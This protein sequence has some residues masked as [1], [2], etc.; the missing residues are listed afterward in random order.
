MWVSPPMGATVWVPL[1]VVAVVAAKPVPCP[2]A[3]RR[4]LG[5]AL[6]GLTPPTRAPLPCPHGVAPRGASQ[7][8]QQPPSRL[9]RARASRGGFWLSASAEQGRGRA[10]DLVRGAPSPLPSPVSFP[11]KWCVQPRASVGSGRAG[12]TGEGEKGTWGM[13]SA[14]GC[15]GN[16]GL[17][18]PFRLAPGV[19]LA[20]TSAGAAGEETACPWL[21]LSPNPLKPPL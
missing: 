15:E 20:Q 17:S 13:W 14:T 7:S 11:F 6:P 4:S 10:A 18:Q 2:R 19:T 9:C 3:L 21:M 8:S 5:K 12:G 1:K 16:P